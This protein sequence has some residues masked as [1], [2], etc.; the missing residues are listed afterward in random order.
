MVL[1]TQFLLIISLQST[2]FTR[3][4]W[5]A[6][7]AQAQLLV[8]PGVSLAL[9][10]L[11]TQQHQLVQFKVIPC[12][13]LSLDVTLLNTLWVMLHFLIVMLLSSS[14]LPSVKNHNLALT[15]LKSFVTMEEMVILSIHSMQPTM[16][17]V[18]L[19]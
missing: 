9:Q 6:C 19:I 4:I 7:S 13:T 12:I 17:P 10:L 14:Q 11:P 8:E 2:S 5:K 18:P 15:F 16:L 3:T 1:Q